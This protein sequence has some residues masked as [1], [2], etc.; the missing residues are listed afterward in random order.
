MHAGK[1]AEGGFLANNSGD[2]LEP[3]W[4]WDS[5]KKQINGKNM[6]WGEICRLKGNINS[7][8]HQEVLATYYIPNHKRG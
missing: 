6:V 1:V 8:K 7:L 3:A 5:P 4:I 2:L